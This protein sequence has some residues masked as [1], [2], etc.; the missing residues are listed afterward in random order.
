MTTK[1]TMDK[2]GRIVIPKPL[3][4]RL[5]LGA[6]DSLALHSEG[7][8]ITLQ[9]VRPQAALKKEYGIW[10]YQGETTDAS[11]S[12]LIDTAREKRLGEFRR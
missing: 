1:L 8:S 6:G 5:R 11:I 10:V 7:E 12:D 9:P 3:R 4:D 2:A